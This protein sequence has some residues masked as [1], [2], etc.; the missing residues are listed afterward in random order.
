MPGRWRV[1]SELKKERGRLFIFGVDC[2]SLD[3]LKTVSF[4]L[5]YGAGIVSVNTRKSQIK[6]GEGEN[7]DK[8]GSDDDE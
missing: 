2:E 1:L 3:Y 8:E 6:S 4:K 7:E 5:H